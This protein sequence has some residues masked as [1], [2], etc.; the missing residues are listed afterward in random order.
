[1]PVYEVPWDCYDQLI[2]HEMKTLPNGTPYYDKTKFKPELAEDMDIGDMSVKDA[3]FPD[4]TSVTAKGC[5]RGTDGC[6][7]AMPVLRTLGD[8]QV[9]CHFA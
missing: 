2:T 1:V 8:R 7:T 3:V 5:P 9:P 4:G 6:K